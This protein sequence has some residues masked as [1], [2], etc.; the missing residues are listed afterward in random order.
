MPSTHKA[1]GLH[2]TDTSI[3]A[4]WL[5]EKD[6]EYEVV[7]FGQKQLPPGL[8]EDGGVINAQGLAN[9]IKNVMANPLWGKFEVRNV[10]CSISEAK[11]FIKP[12]LLPKFKKQNLGEMIMW[13]AQSAV[14]IPKD[15]AYFNWQILSEN[16][17]DG[18]VEVLVLA[19][20]KTVVENILKALELA[21][22]NPIA[23]DLDSFART[24]VIALEEYSQETIMQVHIGMISSTLAVVRHQ[25]V[26]FSSIL[27]I[28]TKNLIEE[29]AAE[30]RIAIPDAA[31]E[32]YKSGTS[33]LPQ[34]NSLLDLVTGISNAIS[35][36]NEREKDPKDKVSKILLTGSNTTIPG[37]IEQLNN[38]FQIKAEIAKPRF[39]FRIPESGN[40]IN[41][42]LT[43]V[44]LA[45]RSVGQK[46]DSDINFLPP[47]TKEEIE[48]GGLRHMV[49]SMVWVFLF[50]LAGSSLLLGVN[51]ARMKLAHKNILTETDVTNRN[52]Q[53]DSVQQLFT[54]VK[55]ANSTLA[56]IDKLQQFDQDVSS[57]LKM[58]AQNIPPGVVLNRLS[59]SDSGI[60]NVGGKSDSSFS[61]LTFKES[62]KKE[63]TVESVEIP[64][65]SLA[66]TKDNLF[67][68]KVV[69]KS[70]KPTENENK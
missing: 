2:I 68:M 55:D 64:L 31:Y 10:V 35:F 5:D 42:L 41:P 36:H 37:L 58:F 60:W 44:G 61:L 52:I 67:E 11:V 18:K 6:G 40:R 22:L 65:S 33:S 53:S 48:T 62:L 1:F 24:R 3:K 7:A 34:K 49:T 16:N 54:W 30:K 23:L 28:G 59:L 15:Q 27:K 26:W 43:V 38:L 12:L 45:I 21:D 9:E 19:V 69:I 51:L 70:S 8:V 56:T 4:T 13:E 25:K 46:F 66:D 14:P 20:E 63:E 32:L 57:N 47:H 39:K 50:T 29:I 17:K